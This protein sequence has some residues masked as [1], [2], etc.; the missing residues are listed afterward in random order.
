MVSLISGPATPQKGE[1]IVFRTIHRIA[2]NLSQAKLLVPVLIV[3]IPLGA[4]AARRGK[5]A[6][7]CDAPSYFGMCDPYV[8]GT[9]GSPISKKG[10]AVFTTWPRGPA[11]KAGICPADTIVAINGQS[12]TKLTSDE[13]LKLMVSAS[14]G[15]V[16]L[17]ITR[18][19]E[20]LN[21]RFKR[22]RESTLIKLSKQ[23][24]L[25]FGGFGGPII[26]VPLKERPKEVEALQSFE[27]Q[28]AAHFGF[29]NVGWAAPVP[30]ATPEKAIQELRQLYSETGRKQVATYAGIGGPK[31]TA[32]AGL[33]VLKNSG[34]VIVNFIEPGSPAN[35]AGLLPG[36]E[37][38]EING[39]LL[40][41]LTPEQLKR[42]FRNLDSPRT[43]T[44]QVRRDDAESVV[45]VTPEDTE[46]VRQSDPL[47]DISQAI[48]YSRNLPAPRPY[49]ATYFVG[50]HV[51]FD[52]TDG[53]A[54]VSRV[55]Y[56]SP[57]FDEGLHPG[58]L[59]LSINGAPIKQL[60][61]AKISSLLTPADSSPI[62][63]KV[64]RLGK[65]LTF[66]VASATHAEAMAKIGR[67]MTK[68]G[69]AAKGC[70]G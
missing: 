64:S 11:E 8:P 52:S 32:G 60:T 66:K 48:V 51:L 6:K 4:F 63:F 25:P 55:E 34:K 45:K 36:D 40:A 22:V 35:H 38:I 43:V 1:L 7:A 9:I 49:G 37:V 12:A 15:P 3:A 61:R 41:G 26:S 58:D 47:L 27:N 67:K 69:P 28:L 31:Y 19:K 62:D 70:A 18:G 53:R 10:F 29:K 24:W 59:V 21:F 65:R 56:P 33:M 57:A 54:M 30:N 68:H 17:T 13:I 20:Q 42:V 14:P 2:N 5:S 50:V 16:S 39:T 44:V 23:K 46:T